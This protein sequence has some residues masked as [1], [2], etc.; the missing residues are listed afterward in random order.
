MLPARGVQVIPGIPV[1]VPPGLHGTRS[2]DEVLRIAV[3]DP[4]IRRHQ[5]VFGR[6]EPIPCTAHA[7]PT[8]LGLVSD[9]GEV[10]PAAI[11]CP[12]PARRGGIEGVLIGRRLGFGIG[13]VPR[14]GCRYVCRAFLTAY[15]N[16]VVPVAFPGGFDADAARERAG[17]VILLFLRHLASGSGLICHFVIGVRVAGHSKDACAD[18]DEREDEG[19][20]DLMKD[21]REHDVRTPGRVIFATFRCGLYAPQE[22]ANGT[23]GAR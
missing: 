22:V 10:V 3:I 14:L 12:V 18:E 20:P 7:Q 1:L 17:R 13:C 9:R 23:L 16:A 4:G 11:S 6:I 15:L 8:G 21:V 2:G 19:D 5:A